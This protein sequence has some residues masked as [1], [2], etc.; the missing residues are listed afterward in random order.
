MTGARAFQRCAELAEAAGD[1]GEGTAPPAQ[2]WFLVEHR[3]AWPRLALQAL[4]PDAA[5]ALGAWAGGTG[6]RIVLVRRPGRR[7][8]RAE[9]LRWFRV[10]A[11]PGH[12]GIR[13]GTWAGAGDLAAAVTAEGDPYDAP[14]TLVCAHGRHDACCAV[15]GR[16]LAAALVA[17][18]PEGTWECSHIG[19]CR[20]A[21]AMVLL[22]HG[23]VYGGVSPL[24]GPSI[25]RDAA[26]GLV[27]PSRLRGRS[28]L[29]PA[30]QAAQ[31]HARLAT[32]SR[33]VDD[34]RVAGVD[35]DGAPAG[36]T[37]W[38]VRFT[39]PDCVVEVK[40][41]FVGVDRPLTCAGRPGGRMRV[42]D[43]VRVGH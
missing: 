28:A 22:P 8:G 23:L 39:G 42:F 38:R 34:L 6:A 29:S 41:R 19:G 11:R 32:G 30:V 25:V 27:V 26:R 16:P 37:A 14:L 21:P 3:G 33:G 2:H 15:R 1:P 5:A 12:E 10:D 17:D 31:Q 7:A 43:P 24:E 36:S 4:D 40:E 13:T 35:S 18:D 20:F 9:G